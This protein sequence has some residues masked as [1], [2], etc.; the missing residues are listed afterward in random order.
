MLTPRRISSYAVAALACGAVAA[1][2]AMADGPSVELREFVNG[3]S[4][5]HNGG[6]SYRIMTRPADDPVFASPAATKSG[7]GD[8][9]LFYVAGGLGLVLVAGGAGLALGRRRDGVPASTRTA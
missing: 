2:G 5:T 4:P 8:D 1:P 9:T 3:T 7:G 6:P